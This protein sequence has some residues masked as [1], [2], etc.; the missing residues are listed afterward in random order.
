MKLRNPVLQN[1]LYRKDYSSEA[2]FKQG[3]AS[4]IEFYN[5]ARPHRTLKNMTPYQMEESLIKGS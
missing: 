1:F 2:A 5:T 4:Y 3:V